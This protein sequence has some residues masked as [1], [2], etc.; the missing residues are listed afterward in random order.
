MNFIK[1]LFCKR[2]EKKELNKIKSI[3]KILLDKVKEKGL[4]KVIMGIKREME[5]IEK[6]KDKDYKMVVN[7]DIVKYNSDDLI[8][9]SIQRMDEEIFYLINSGDELDIKRQMYHIENSE[10]TLLDICAFGEIYKFGTGNDK[11]QSLIKKWYGDYKL[12]EKGI[13]CNE[14][15]NY[16]I[17]N[18]SS[19]VEIKRTLYLSNIYDRHY[20][21]FGNKMFISS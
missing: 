7:Y 12:I 16:S 20:M 19:M 18:I 17:E 10:E 21:D 15:Y 6:V 8:V 13:G 11:L 4:V 9:S 5:Y 3:E 14:G 1:E 2:T